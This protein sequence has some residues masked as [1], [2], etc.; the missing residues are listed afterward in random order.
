MIDC[1]M[2]Y[3]KICPRESNLSW[4]KYCHIKSIMPKSFQ[5]NSDRIIDIINTKYVDD[6]YVQMDKSVHPGILTKP[7]KI[8]TITKEIYERFLQFV[9]DE[10]IPNSI[11]C[12]F[13]IGKISNI[14]VKSVH[15]LESNDLTV[16]VGRILDSSDLTGI[17]E[18]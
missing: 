9:I 5:L 11:R 17:F 7:N 2:M 1:G 3:I 10:G 18:V 6:I 13:S 8:Y 14:N 16:K 15:Y 12:V 4:I